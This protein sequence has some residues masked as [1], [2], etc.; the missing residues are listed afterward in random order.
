[1]ELNIAL[2][3][4]IGYLLGSLN[5]S[6]IVGKLYKIDVRNHGSGNAGATNTL[7]V[8]GKIPA[9]LV[10][11]G[12]FLKGAI[13]C[14]IGRYLAG[15]TFPQVYAGEYI[16]GL[17]AV[18]GHNW[19][20]YFGFKGGKGVMTSFAVVLMF[21][22]WAALISL[23]CFIVIVALTKYVSLGSMIGA[24]LFPIAA[25]LLKEPAMMVGTGA[26]LGLLIVV[27]HRSN[28][29]R[30]IAGEEKKLSFN[31]KERD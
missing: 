19:P 30:L 23:L 28:I 4:V 13:A 11:L 21:S 7:R 22:P 27:R 1:M 9:L 25:F 17:F 10:V 15:E 6:I 31:K 29:K 26:F 12:D 16:G 3:A 24:V 5:T 14:L 2:S 8:L 18:L 20:V